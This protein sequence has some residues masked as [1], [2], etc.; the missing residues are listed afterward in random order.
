LIEKVE[1]LTG[2]SNLN[3]SSDLDV[4]ALLLQAA[5]RGAGANVI[6]NLDSIADDGYTGSLLS[7]LEVCTHQIEEV[8][9]QVHARA[10]AR[11]LREPEAE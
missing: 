2:R 7:E 1:S 11:D 5:A 3:A 4:G 9:A 10:H 6:I 8:A